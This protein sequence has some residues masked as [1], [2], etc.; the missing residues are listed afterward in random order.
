MFFFFFPKN[1]QYEEMLFL[2]VLYGMLKCV[3]GHIAILLQLKRPDAE[4]ML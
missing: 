1:A 4:K 2:F 3:F